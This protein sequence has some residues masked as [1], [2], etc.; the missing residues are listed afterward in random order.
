MTN[1]GPTFAGRL[2]CQCV[3][4]ISRCASGTAVGLVFDTGRQVVVALPGPPRELQPMVRDAL[5]PYLNKRFGNH[6]PAV[7]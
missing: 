7:R 1:C 4:P 5:V 6:R 2:K 3:A